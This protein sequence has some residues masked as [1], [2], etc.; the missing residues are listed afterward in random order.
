[1][2]CRGLP[3]AHQEALHDAI[4]QYELSAEEA[5]RTARALKRAGLA[6]DAKSATAFID[7]LR[8]EREDATGEGDALSR[9]AGL[10]AAIEAAAAGERGSAEALAAAAR[11]AKAPPFDGDRLRAEVLALAR[12]LARTPADELV[13]GGAAYM[14]LSML[15]GTL[16][17]LLPADCQDPKRCFPCRGRST[18]MRPRLFAAVEGVMK[19]TRGVRRL[20][21]SSFFWRCS[22]AADRCPRQRRRPRPRPRL[23]ARELA[24]PGTPASAELTLGELAERVD[25]AW[26]AVRSYRITFTGSTSARPPAWGH[27]SRGRWRRRARRPWRPQERRPWPDRART[28]VSIRKWSCP[29]GSDRTCA[30]LGANDHEAIAIGDRLYVRGPLVEQIAPGTPE[31]VWIVVDPSTLPEGSMLSRLLGGLPEVPGA[32]LASL[33]ERLLPQVVREMDAVEHDGREC[34]VYGAADT[35][36]ATGMRVDYTIAVDDRDIPCFIETSAGGVTQGR[37]EYSDIDGSFTIEPPAAATPVSVP[38]AL[39]TP[40]PTTSRPT[41]L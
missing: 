12:T 22:P 19:R 40:W 33:P 9:A 27:R 25:A 8:A 23:P 17:A 1:M 10:F 39:A 24:T 3:A 6:D 36:Q 15:R 41:R 38:A 5:M 16:D 30:A 11:T 20:S 28:F 21:W 35:V 4:I 32:P 2:P 26:P 7:A 13:P 29:I 31:D 37:D 18:L 14:P 34:R